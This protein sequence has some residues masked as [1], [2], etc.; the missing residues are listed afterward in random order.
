ML[1]PHYCRGGGIKTSFQQFLLDSVFDLGMP[2][3][4]NSSAGRNSGEGCDEAKMSFGFKA[5]PLHE[6]DWLYTCGI[7]NLMSP[8]II[9]F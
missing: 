3:T 1:N 2:I 8:K 9:G 6:K 7:W 5:S 4:S